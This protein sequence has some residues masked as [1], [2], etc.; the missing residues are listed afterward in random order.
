MHN[1]KADPNAI[2]VT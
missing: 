1:N 2:N